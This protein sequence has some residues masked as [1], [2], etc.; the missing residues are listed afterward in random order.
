MELRDKLCVQVLDWKRIALVISYGGIFLAPAGHYWYK[1]LDR[2]LGSK[3]NPS[4]INF[5]AG[6]V[7][8]SLRQQCLP[9]KTPSSSGKLPLQVL[10][11]NLVF[12]PIH[13]ALFFSMINFGVESKTLQVRCFESPTN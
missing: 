8:L 9:I 12:S 4:T 3:F 7:Q 11:D 13:I 1:A 10:V 5:V 6:K 2:A